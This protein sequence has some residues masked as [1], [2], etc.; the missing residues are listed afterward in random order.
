MIALITGKIGGGKTLHAVGEIVRHLAKGGTVCTNIDLVWDELCLVCLERYRV[1]LQPEQLRMIDL[2]DDKGW[3]VAVPFGMPSGSVLVVLDEIHLFFNA[4][5]WASTQKQHR[6]LVSFLSQSRKVHVEVRFLC[7]SATTLEKQ[8]RL[9]C[10]FEY[11]MR[12]VKDI[13]IPLLGTLPMNRLLMVTRDNAKDSSSKPLAHELVKYD[14]RL[15]RCYNTYALLDDH[16]IQLVEDH[17]RVGLIPLRRRPILSFN[18][19]HLTAFAAAFLFC[20]WLFIRSRF[21]P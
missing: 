3:H 15:F 20:L 4:R 14:K 9:Q 19:S 10:E 21:H 8:F 18:R 7:Q 12:N 16:M 13:K 17:E 5:D 1:Y 2:K 11:Y 6:D